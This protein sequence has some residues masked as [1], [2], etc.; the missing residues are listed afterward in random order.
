MLGREKSY[1]NLCSKSPKA[2]HCEFTS[3]HIEDVASEARN[4]R[5][6][7]GT[8]TLSDQRITGTRGDPVK[9][10]PRGVRLQRHPSDE[11]KESI[12][13]ERVRV[14][15]VE[16]AHRL[17]DR[18]QLLESHQASS[19]SVKDSLTVLSVNSSVR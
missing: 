10:Q 8:V 15:S 1:F 11:S 3:L 6:G 14:P 19:N 4:V 9:K 18:D 5:S 17:H 13:E 7:L 16:E 12:V 2:N